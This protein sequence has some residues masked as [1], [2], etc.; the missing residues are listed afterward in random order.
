M[1]AAKFKADYNAL[2]QIAKSFGTEAEQSRQSISN[3]K[4]KMEVLKGGHWLGDSA[5]KFYNEMD[6][7]VLPAY[8]RLSNALDSAQ[9]ITTKI[10]A[11]A[12]QAEG[13]S[14]RVFVFDGKGGQGTPGG[15]GA[16]AGGAGGGNGA[17]GPGGGGGSGGPGGGGSSGPNKWVKGEGSYYEWGRTGGKGS[18][19]KSFGFKYGIAK[20]SVYGDANAPTGVSALGGEA[21][22]EVGIESFKKGRVGIFAEGYAAKA[23]GET[24]FAGDKDLGFTGSGEVKAVSA[25]GFAGLKD[26][27]LGASA[28]ITLVSAKGELGANVAGYNVGLNAEVGIKAELGLKVGKKTEIKLPFVTLGFSFGGAKG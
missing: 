3:L 17:G 7:A 2:N 27:S 28:G 11:I 10:S 4:S 25:G 16:G 1:P 22:I 12:K 14:S 21:G 23:Q 15:N 5:K 19:E 24:L 8:T 18:G 6:S 9:Q 20:D 26:G 13:D